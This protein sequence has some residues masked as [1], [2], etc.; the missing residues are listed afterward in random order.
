MFQPDVVEENPL[1]QPWLDW[2]FDQRVSDV[3]CE[4]LRWWWQEDVRQRRSRQQQKTF[5]WRECKRC[6]WNKRWRRNWTKRGWSQFHQHFMSSLYANF[7]SP[8]NTNT[9]CK[10]S[11]T[12]LYK[13][14]ACKMLMK[15]APGVN[16]INVFTC[17]FNL[18]PQIP[19]AQKA[20]W[21]DFFCAFGICAR[22][23]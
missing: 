5:E 17:S 6:K 21:V 14:A 1:H 8:K 7:L 10:H 20:A 9:N 22:K 15:L 11:K 12:L 2:D 13:K 4:W 16:F 18:R 23:T 19:K 3:Q